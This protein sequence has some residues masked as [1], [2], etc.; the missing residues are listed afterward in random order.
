MPSTVITLEQLGRLVVGSVGDLHDQLLQTAAQRKVDRS[1]HGHDLITILQRLDLRCPPLGE[2]V[3]RFLENLL[4]QNLIQIVKYLDVVVVNLEHGPLGNTLQMALQIVG[5]HFQQRL[6][7]SRDNCSAKLLQCSAQL[8][9]RV[10]ELDVKLGK[11]RVSP[12]DN[13]LGLE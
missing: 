1:H 13:L 6:D 11:K 5:S 3:Q 10:H 4:V 9:C 12:L 2:I 8:S 7:S